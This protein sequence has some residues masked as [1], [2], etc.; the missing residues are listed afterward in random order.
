MELCGQRPSF[1]AARRFGA[2]SLGAFCSVLRVCGLAGIWAQ[3][4]APLQTAGQFCAHVGDGSHPVPISIPD[5]RHAGSCRGTHLQTLVRKSILRLQRRPQPLLHARP[6]R[7]ENTVI[8]GVA[9]VAVPKPP[10]PSKGAFAHGAEPFNR[11]L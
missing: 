3:H 8:N 4:A 7:I 2:G 5:D 1:A 11:P 10:L 9:D 6:L